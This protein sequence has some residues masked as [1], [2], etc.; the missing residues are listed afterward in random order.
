M[1]VH[2]L[3]SVCFTSATPG[4]FEGDRHDIKWW[5]TFTADCQG[6][7]AVSMDFLQNANKRE[8]LVVKLK[9]K[10]PYDGTVCW[11]CGR[12]QRQGG[13][14]AARQSWPIAKTRFSPANQQTL[15]FPSC[16]LFAVVLVCPLLLIDFSKNAVRFSAACLTSKLLLVTSQVFVYAQKRD[17]FWGSRFSKWHSKVKICNSINCCDSDEMKFTNKLW[18]NVR[19]KNHGKVSTNTFMLELV[20][21]A[22]TK[23][24]LIFSSTFG[25]N[26]RT[27]AAA[28]AMPIKGRASAQKETIEAALR[29]DDAL[30][31]GQQIVQVWM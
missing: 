29:W 7:Q 14:F 21:E 30:R 26:W 19:E 18:W 15:S 8:S 13:A 1:D 23:K 16:R 22:D 10:V 6:R 4:I 25:M 3:R 27:W 24:H 9:R 2:Y 11:C 28:D 12:W 17:T 5:C 20:L 31:P